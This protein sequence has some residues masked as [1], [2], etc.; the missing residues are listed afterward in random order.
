MMLLQVLLYSLIALT[1]VALALLLFRF[2]RRA[3][4]APAVASEP[5]QPQL[6]LA[7]ENL[8]PEQLPEDG[9]TRLAAELMGK[10]EWR[11]A[12]RA[13]YLA[14]LAHLAQRNLI[15]LARFKSNR[16]YERE[17]RRRAHA[18]PAAVSVFGENVSVFEGIWYGMHEVNG[19]LVTRF[20][21]KVEQLKRAE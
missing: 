12:V 5:L 2:W 15:S 3:P 20:A 18:F 19:D 14:S 10:G 8:G 6:D 9:W 17:L 13:F 11:L 16:D 4:K 21:A 7:D 1:A